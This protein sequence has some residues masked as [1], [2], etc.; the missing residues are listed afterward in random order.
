MKINENAVS[1]WGSSLLYLNTCTPG[2]G[3]QP[4]SVHRQLFALGYGVPHLRSP[5]G[6]ENA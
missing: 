1:W 6:G 4:R 3:N 5:P 2:S